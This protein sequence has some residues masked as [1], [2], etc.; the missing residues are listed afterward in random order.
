MDPAR[1]RKV[2]LVVALTA[3]LLLAGTL[4]YTSFASGTATKTPSQVLAAGS[5]GGTY[6]M[7]GKV[8]PGSIS[9]QGATLVFKVADRAGAA[10]S[11]PVHYQGT[12]PDPFRE[13]REVIVTGRLQNGTFAAERDTL[14]TKCPSKFQ[15]DKSGNT[16]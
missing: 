10:S 13:G 7:T 4:L 6:E 1:K 15:N 5:T 9:H 14:V 3:A 12:V 11:V 8:V 16:T 2:R